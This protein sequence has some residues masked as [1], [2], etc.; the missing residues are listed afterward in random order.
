MPCMQHA[1]LL[2]AARKVGRVVG[3][4]PEGVVHGS[5]EPRRPAPGCASFPMDVVPACFGADSCHSGLHGVQAIMAY[6]CSWWNMLHVL[7]GAGHQEGALD[8]AQLRRWVSRGDGPAAQKLLTKLR[9][10]T[11]GP[12]FDWTAR[13]YDTEQPYKSLP[14]ELHALACRLSASAAKCLPDRAGMHM[15]ALAHSSPGISPWRLAS[16]SCSDGLLRIKHK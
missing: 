10:C 14:A 12:Q 5:R 13:V 2:Q 7:T 15:N 1:C 4:C 16:F 9:W 6:S 3:G 11:L 8:R